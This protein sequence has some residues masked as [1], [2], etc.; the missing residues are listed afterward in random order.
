VKAIFL[1]LAVAA[2]FATAGCVATKNP[3]GTIYVNGK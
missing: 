2:L 3:D 1:I